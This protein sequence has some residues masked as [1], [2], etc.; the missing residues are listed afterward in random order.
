MKSILTS[1]LCFT[2]INLFAQSQQHSVFIDF[3]GAASPAPWHTISSHTAGAI[4]ELY[5]A[6]GL[7]TGIS[8]EVYDAF[9]GTNSSGTTLPDT[10]LGIPG[11]ASGDS[12]YGNTEEFSGG[13]EPTGGI[14]LSNLDVNVRYTFTLFASRIATD[15]RETKYILHGMDSDSAL[16]Q[17]AGNT[18]DIVELS[19]YP[20]AQGEIKLQVRPGPNNN[21]TYGF[22][23][24]GAMKMNFVDSIDFMPSLQLVQ[25][26]GG[27][28][29]EVGE[30]VAIRWQNTS[31]SPCELAYSTNDGQ[32]WSIIDTVPAFATAYTWTVPNNPSD[33]CLIR[34]RADT[35]DIHSPMN[36]AI[37]PAGEPCRIVVIGSSTAA[38][39]GVSTSDSAW[40]NRFRNF[41]EP[42]DTRIEVINLARGGYTTYHLLP[43]GSSYGQEV[44]INADTARNIT[45]ALSLHP[46]AVIINLPSNDASRGY[47]LDTQMRNFHEMTQAANNEMVKAFVCTTQPKNFS[48]SNRINLQ[49]DV[50]DSI[51]SFYGDYAIDF[52]STIALPNG[53]I[54]PT[55]NSGD[56]THLNDAGHRILFQRVA[57]QVLTDSL[58]NPGQV[59]VIDVKKQ[60]VDLSIFPNPASSELYVQLD[61]IPSDS[62]SIVVTLFDAM[63]R[64]LSKQEATV[65]AAQQLIKVD[66]NQITQQL[67][68]A[69]IVVQVEGK[70]YRKSIGKSILINR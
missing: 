34:L 33:A 69:F 22:F 8:V 66:L 32:A 13:T 28:N 38:G 6:A 17:V 45:K 61:N 37:I 55:Y 29:W 60:N 23:Y 14:R 12:F 46:T 20:D 30:E 44:N 35:F 18:S 3:G 27:E 41:V 39:A 4:D 25:P 40:V 52:W 19:Q 9:R 59:S 57:D 48:D 65:Y 53:T 51:F 54:D 49:R 24:L 47:S 16:L 31:L 11:T 26:T 2:C 56:G 1:L 64:S 62:E 50:R 5:T 42:E 7:P 36:Y 67:T 15:N 58:C 10:S 21:N 43:T 63:G 68:F 70:N